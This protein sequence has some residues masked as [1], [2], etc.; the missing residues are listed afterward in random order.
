MQMSSATNPNIRCLERESI[1]QS[2]S[3]LF[4]DA[5]NI[6]VPTISTDLFDTGILDSQRF[7]EL[8]LRIEQQF[9]TRISID[10]FELER[11]RCIEQIARLIFD[12]KNSF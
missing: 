9:N 3:Q 4:M 6:R 11:F 8:L 10:D 2:L 1:Q 7:I 12:C 5:F